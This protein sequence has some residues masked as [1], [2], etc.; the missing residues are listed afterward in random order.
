ME[1]N[2]E[3]TQTRRPGLI[4][5]PRIIPN[6]PEKTSEEKAPEAPKTGRKKTG[7]ADGPKQT[8]VNQQRNIKISKETKKQLDVLL[9]FSGHKFAYEL[10]D[11]M[12]DVYLDNA[13]EPDQ[14]RAFKTLYK[15]MS[16]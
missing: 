10:I 13:L 8:N 12:I 4:R 2:N 11:S 5:Q 9:K 3:N 16:D 7:Q 6:L 15:H 14:K 1:N